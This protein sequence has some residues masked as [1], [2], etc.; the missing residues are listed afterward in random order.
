[1]IKLNQKINQNF[2]S[3][4]QISNNELKYFQFCNC[5]RKYVGWKIFLIQIVSYKQ[6]VPKNVTRFVDAAHVETIQM[7]EVCPTVPMI[8]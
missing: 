2:Q 6:N 4:N 8:L 1:M 3:N 7:V 5:T